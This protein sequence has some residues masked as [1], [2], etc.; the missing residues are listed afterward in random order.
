MA[1][2][3]ATYANWWG[4]LAKR[5]I[6]LFVR[7]IPQIFTVSLARVKQ[8]AALYGGVQTFMRLIAS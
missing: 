4:P 3:L 2:E 5:E 7:S 6:D 8:S 1:E